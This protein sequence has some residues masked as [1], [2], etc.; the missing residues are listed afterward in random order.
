MSMDQCHSTVGEMPVVKPRSFANTQVGVNGKAYWRSVEDLADTGEFRDWLEQEFPSGAS[1]LLD[2][3][4]RTFV[5]LMGASLALAGAATLPGCRRPDHKILPYSREV[6]EEIIPGK[7]LYFATSVHLPGGSVEGLL[8]ETHE[9]RPIKVEGNPLHPTNN[10]KSSHWAQACILGMYDPDRLKDPVLVEGATAAAASHDGHGQTSPGDQGAPPRSWADFEAWSK[11]HLAKFADK[12]GEGLAFLVDKRRGPSRAAIKAAVLKKF[13]K[14]AWVAYDPVQSDAPIEASK[15]V[16]GAPMREVLSLEKADVI[17]AFDRDFLMDDPDRV[18]NMRGYAAKRQ[19]L[20]KNDGMSRIYAIESNFS[21]TGVKADHRWAVPA[22]AIPAYVAALAREI[23]TRVHGG[24][25]FPLAS[26]LSG[27]G[28]NVPVDLAA[29]KAIA[30]D[31]M[32]ARGKSVIV[33]GPTQ[34]AVVHALVIALNAALGNVGNTVAYRPMGDD[35]AATLPALRSLVKDMESGRIDTLVTIGANPVYDA[36]GDL[37]FAATFAKVANRITASTDNT[38]TVAA[39]TWRLP[40]SHALESWGDTEAWDGTIA[41]MQPM[42][43]PLYATKSDIEIL[44]IVSGAA[45][46]D[47]Y[48]FVRTA[49]KA[50]VKGDFERAWRRTLHDG[51]LAGVTGAAAP[52]ETKFDI[53]GLG[54]LLVGAKDNFA[55][56]PEPSKMEVVF[57]VGMPGDGRFAN[58]GWLQEL[59]DPLTKIVWDNVALVSPNV[60]DKYDLRQEK[61]TNKY[62]HARMITITVG[63]QKVT[64]PAWKMAGIPDNTVVV[65]VG[66][67]RKVCGLVGNDVGSNVF[68]LSGTAHAD[69]GANRRVATG[70]TIQRASEG[71]SWWEISTTQM[72]GSMEGRAIVREVDLPAWSK[73]A[74]ATIKD[75]DHYGQDR[76]LKFAERLGELSHAPANINAYVNPQQNS[77]GLAKPGRG[78]TNEV[79]Q[80]PPDYARQPQWGMSIDLATCTGCS[81]CT[82]A[83]QAENNIPIVGK[84]EVNKGREMHWI[85]VDRYFNGHNDTDQSLGVMFQPV[86]CVQCENA[87]CEVVCPVN[88]TTHGPEGINYMVYNRCIGTRYCANNCPYKVRRFNFFQWGTKKYQGGY[89]GKETLDDIGI[90]GPRNHNLIPARLREEL[91]EVQKLQQNPDVTV[92]ARG[93]MEKCTYCIQRINEA[94]IEMKL[95]DLKNIPDGFFQTACQQACPADAIVF[96]DIYDHDSRVS[97]LRDNTRTYM[98]LGYLNTRPR[99]TYLA[100]IRNPNPALASAERKAGW[101]NPFGHGGGH[102]GSESDHQDHGHGDA[103]HSMLGV[104]GYDATKTFDDR[105]YKMSLAVL[106]GKA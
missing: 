65:Q 81:A 35:E 63:D 101:E 44:L 86:A 49:W 60:A 91:N 64:L 28:S 96:G 53:P 43:A 92:R 55:R 58:H 67:G 20:T 56:M 29:V 84:I 100:S 22:S 32:K 85:R 95:R 46:A 51:V 2:S 70:A 25:D 9:G 93:V 79:G 72:H 103:K 80:T 30:D 7:P 99:T 94:R 13:P 11:R 74:D 105:G 23:G 89:I 69:G 106:G 41:P 12:G 1:R 33:A 24:G 16:L 61:Q 50:L 52:P 75:K 57:A 5:K 87:P 39:S 42:I 73:F 62:R 10:G 31:L 21:T 3:S 71:P 26:E 15:A 8:V 40:M 36:P 83:C 18:R 47:G 76:E 98:L 48:E 97:K 27:L 90:G 102:G 78:E 54:R 17:V 37:H 14:A 19:V 77:K 88:A 66:Y 34:S 4:R 68:P 59:P 82:I 104:G 45:S 6:P 38:E